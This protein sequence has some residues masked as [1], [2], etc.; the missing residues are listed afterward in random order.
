MRSTLFHIPHELGGLPVLGF[1]WLLLA[2]A[3]VSLA[4]LAMLIKRQGWNQDTASYLPFMGIVAAAIVFLLP[5][6]E[7]VGPGGTPLGLPIRGFGVMLMFAVV[8]GVGLAAYRAQQMGLDPEL[9]YTLAFWMFVSGIVGARGF[10]I[11]QYWPQFQKDNLLDTLKALANVTNG[12]LVVYGSVLLSV[13]VGIWFLRS[14]RL[15]VLAIGDIIAPSMVV[16]LALGRVGCFL[17]GCCFGGVCT[18]N[19]PAQ[20][21]PATSPP[22]AQHVAEGWRSGVWLSSPSAAAQAGQPEQVIVGYV[23]PGGAAASAGLKPGS[24]IKAI[25]GRQVTG[26]EQARESLARATHSYEVSLASGEVLRWT[27]QDS[28]ARSAPVHPAQLYASIDAG[29]LALLLWVVYPFRRRDG[30]VFALL[31]TLHPLSRFLLELVRS[32]EGGQFGTQLTI[33]QWLSIGIFLAACAFWVFIE[34]RPR[35]SALPLAPKPTN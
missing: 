26:L 35:G 7:E 24:V 33:S 12:G 11:L 1:G 9:I 22:Y 34:S 6:M 14:R 30:E 27:N 18:S 29:L 13:P 32:D 31:I 21:F 2:W 10:Y 28:P 19:L 17:N 16:G 8:A 25:N 5:G 15:P 20:T 3:I 23:L 4:L